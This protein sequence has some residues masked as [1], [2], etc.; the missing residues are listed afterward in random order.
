MTAGRE[1]RAVVQQVNLRAVILAV[2][3]ESREI[4]G[5]VPLLLVLMMKALLLVLLDS[6]RT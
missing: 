1:S 6:P 4:K 2:R 3:R 5:V